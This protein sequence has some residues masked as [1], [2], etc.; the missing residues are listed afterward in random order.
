MPVIKIRNSNCNYYKLFYKILSSYIPLVNK[1]ERIEGTRKYRK[2]NIVSV[3]K[4]KG[5]VTYNCIGGG[6]DCETSTTEN[7]SFPYCT[8]LAIKD[9]VIIDFYP[10]NIK[11]MFEG[12]STAFRELFPHT[13]LMLFNANLGYEY[14][15]F[16]HYLRPL[17][18]KENAIFAKTKRKIL[19]C[20]ICD[21]IR[22]TECIGLFGNSLSNIADTYCKT[23]KLVGDLNYNKIRLP[24]DITGMNRSETDYCINDVKILSELYGYIFEYYIKR[25]VKVPPTKTGFVRQDLKKNLGSRINF[26]KNDVQKYLKDKAHYDLCRKYLYKGGLTH[27]LYSVKGER[28]YN[29]TCVD[30]TSAYPYT[31]AVKYFPA[32]DLIHIKPTIEN[33]KKVVKNYKHWYVQLYIHHMESKSNHSTESVHKIQRTDKTSLVLDN[34]RILKAKNIVL[35]VN[36]VDFSSLRKIYNFSFSIVSLSYFTAS[37][38][39]PEYIRDLV[40]TYF[41]NKCVIGAD[42]KEKEKIKKNTTDEDVL[43]ELNKTIR[44]LKI[45]YVESKEKVNSVY[46]CTGT[47]VQTQNILLDDST[48][49]LKEGTSKEWEEAI[50]SVFLSP[51]LAYWCTSYVRARL[52]EVISVFPDSVYQ[53]D[54][55]SLYVDNTNTELMSFIDKINERVLNECTTEI[56]E[57]KYEVCRCLG[58][59]ELDGTYQYMLPMGSKRYLGVHT[60]EEAITEF[61]KSNTL[62]NR[63]PV[64]IK[65]SDM[66]NVTESFIDKVI[67]FDCKYKLTFAGARKYDVYAYCAYNNIDVEEFVKHMNL[68]A[69]YCTK[70]SPEYFDTARTDTVTDD[71]NNTMTIT[72]LSGQILKNVPFKADLDTNLY[73]SFKKS[74]KKEVINYVK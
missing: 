61:N 31:Y 16:K 3:G 71:K 67:Y 42:K 21:N 6:F 12:L 40:L 56:P 74:N 30:L 41:Y 52:I 27:S 63:T 43:N 57:K 36:E 15:F 66:Y 10:E 14:S 33:F 17:M 34:G 22:I 54:T 48:G 53:Y 51:Y 59:W 62:S 32:G 46:G 4:G 70:L 29:I 1:T 28:K 11:N 69:D 55:D 2:I 44:R 60:D 35:M 8:Q 64:K 13:T 9:H 73:K 37:T 65:Y 18:I 47:E 72:W 20:N 45:D 5:K 24:H 38:K 58:K 23:K 50:K 68:T 26:V 49:D 19:T 7:M 39:C 25:G